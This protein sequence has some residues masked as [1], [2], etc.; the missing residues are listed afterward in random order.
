M[1]EFSSVSNAE[2]RQGKPYK[3]S[4][5]VKKEYRPRANYE[6]LSKKEKAVIDHFCVDH[7][8]WNLKNNNMLNI[9]WIAG[10]LADRI[11]KYPDA[12]INED[13]KAVI[14]KLAQIFEEW[15]LINERL[16]GSDTV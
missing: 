12:P 9:M 8:E 3:F 4:P 15:H 6:F 10:I 7:L 11:M 1:T 16:K 5:Q 14:E 2:I 13:H